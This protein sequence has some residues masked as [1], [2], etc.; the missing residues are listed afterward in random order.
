MEV[1]IWIGVDDQ[2]RMSPGRRLP[3]QQGR[4]CGFADS[5]FAA[6]RNFHDVSLTARPNGRNRSSFHHRGHGE[7]AHQRL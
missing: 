7:A 6:E 2:N 5:A 3:G 1:R 4:Q